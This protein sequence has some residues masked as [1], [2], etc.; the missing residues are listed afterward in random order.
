M[1]AAII[2]V[3]AR[4]LFSSRVCGTPTALAFLL[5]VFAMASFYRSKGADNQ[6]WIDVQAAQISSVIDRLRT[7]L[8]SAR[9]SARMLFLK[10]PFDNV[11]NAVW[12]TFFVTHLLYRDDTIELDRVALRPGYD[13]IFTVDRERLVLVSPTN[14]SSQRHQPDRRPE[15]PGSPAR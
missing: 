15:T 2:L 10:D 14:E 8:P 5:L 12:A 11:P 13:Y 7:I 9:M 1:F 3:K 4:G 6:T